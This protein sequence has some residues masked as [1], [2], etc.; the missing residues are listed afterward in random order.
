MARDLTPIENAEVRGSISRSCFMTA[1]SHASH[2]RTRRGCYLGRVIR[3]EAASAGGPGGHEKPYNASSKPPDVAFNFGALA[4]HAEK[5][6][7]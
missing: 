1:L 4:L 3:A 5:H 7:M 2:Q 6:L